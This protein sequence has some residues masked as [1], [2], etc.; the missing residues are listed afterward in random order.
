MK[1][2]HFFQIYTCEPEATHAEIKYYQI[3]SYDV[4]YFN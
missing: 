3:R 4:N 1:P 2:D